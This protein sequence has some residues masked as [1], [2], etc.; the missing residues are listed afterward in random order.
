V[1]SLSSAA[2]HLFASRLAEFVADLRSWLETASPA[3][4]FAEQQRDI[5]LSL[6]RA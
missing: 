6:W 5:T 1:L 2:P 3:G 4:I